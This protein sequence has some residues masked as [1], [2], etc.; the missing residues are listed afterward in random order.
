MKLSHIFPLVLGCSAVGIVAS[1]SP[2]HALTWSWSYS[3][4]GVAASGSFTTTTTGSGEQIT[5][6]SGSRSR[7]IGPLSTFAITSAVPTA[8]NGADNIV[9]GIPPH[10][11]NAGFSFQVPIGSATAIWN[12]NIRRTATGWQEFRQRGTSTV[13]TAVNFSA[14]PIPFDIPGGAAIPS[15][16]GLFALGLMR[17]MK[18]KIASNTC[19]ANPV[20]KVVS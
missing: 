11:S 13:A 2:A 3:G 10:L 14:T 12:V 5:A 9:S 20:T 1:T 16:G 8:F 6:L 4:V 15:V 19:I 17:K 18:K 7:T